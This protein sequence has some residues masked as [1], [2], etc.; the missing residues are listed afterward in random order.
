M[1]IFLIAVKAEKNDTD[2][3]VQVLLS[4]EDESF[5][6]PVDARVKFEVEEMSVNEAALFLIDYID[7]YFEEFLLE[8][9]EELYLPIDWKDFEYEAVNFQMKGQIFNKSLEN[10]A[11]ELLRQSEIKH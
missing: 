3:L 4:N 2:V 1:L 7:V 8:E 9:D 11:D 10:M 5:F 6:Y